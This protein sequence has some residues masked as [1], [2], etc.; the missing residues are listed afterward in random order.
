MGLSTGINYLFRREVLQ[1]D[2]NPFGD[3][4]ITEAIKAAKE[5]SH[6]LNLS[7]VQNDIILRKIT[8]GF[9]LRIL[10]TQKDDAST[11]FVSPLVN[12]SF[13]ENGAADI[14]WLVITQPAGYRLI[15]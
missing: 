7:C 8:T 5:S 2:F 9:L 12:T 13:L 10:L 4:S 6:C 1:R 11:T 15:I 14:L 3:E